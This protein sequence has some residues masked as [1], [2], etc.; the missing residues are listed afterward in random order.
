MAGCTF[1]FPFLQK[2]F[3]FEVLIFL[4]IQCTS[5]AADVAS[6]FIYAAKLPLPYGPNFLGLDELHYSID[7][8]T[9]G[10]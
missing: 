7:N 5:S 2:F 1:F 9:G 10:H 8:F 6:F 3:I 4:K